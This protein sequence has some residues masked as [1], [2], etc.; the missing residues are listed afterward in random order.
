MNII[1]AYAI[2][3]VGVWGKKNKKETAQERNE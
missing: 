2:K 3:E 1:T